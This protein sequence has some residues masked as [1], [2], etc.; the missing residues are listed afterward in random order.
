MSPG[1]A[2]I[3]KATYRLWRTRQDQ[4]LR[5]GDFLGAARATAA[6]VGV[7]EAWRYARRRDG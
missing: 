3:L 4:A 6:L 7:R 1:A 5:I 2:R